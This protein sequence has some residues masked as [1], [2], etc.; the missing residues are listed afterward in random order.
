[1]MR[2]AMVEVVFVDVGVHPDALLQQSLVVLRAWQRREEEELENI[3]G[4]LALDDLD[5]PQDR[6]LCIRGEAEDVA[7]ERERAMGAPLLQHDA[8]FGDLVLPLLGGDEI[9]GVDVL[10]P[11]KDAP[12]PRFR[13]LLDEIRNLVAQG[14]DL[15]SEAAVDALFLKLDHPVEQDLPVAV[16]GEVV[17]RDKKPVDSLLPVLAND[18]FQII[19]RAEA[20][21]APLHVD[22]GAERALIGTAA[23]EVDG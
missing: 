8:I 6:F 10:E 7:G 17:V 3:E 19:G 2:D 16:A 9:L 20:A 5:I 15:D 21:L 4:Q 23:P 1:M 14:V 22:D 13:R 11:D 12:R 18:L